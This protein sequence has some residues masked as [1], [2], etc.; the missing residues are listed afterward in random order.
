M[1]IIYTYI[2]GPPKVGHQI[3]IIHF[4]PSPPREGALGDTAA[5]G[6]RSRML[7]NAQQSCEPATAF[8]CF[9]FYISN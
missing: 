7:S 4:E 9:C 3:I 5:G 8:S 2:L 1:I 6:Y